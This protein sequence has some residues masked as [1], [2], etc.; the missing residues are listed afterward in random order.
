MRSARQRLRALGGATDKREN[1][2]PK[3][4]EVLRVARRS[5]YMQIGEL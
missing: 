4:D 5:E 3:S 1:C 2:G